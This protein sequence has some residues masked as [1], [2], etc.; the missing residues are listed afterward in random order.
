MEVMVDM[1]AR[2]LEASREARLWI[3]Q[4]IIPAAICG[5]VIMSKPELRS[6]IKTKF[7]NVKRNIGLRLIK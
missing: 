2:Q 4:V 6:K 1:T 3:R 5:V 7:N